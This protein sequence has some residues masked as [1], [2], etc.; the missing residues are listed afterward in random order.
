VSH[1]RKRQASILLSVVLLLPILVA[2]V[3][4]AYYPEDTFGSVII[5]VGLL[6]TYTVYG[7]VAVKRLHQREATGHGVR[8]RT[9]AS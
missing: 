1:R 4:W 7:L 9:D 6:L 3:L 5:G 8:R 2:A